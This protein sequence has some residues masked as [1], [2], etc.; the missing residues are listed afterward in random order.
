MGDEFAV[1]AHAFPMQI[2]AVVQF[3]VC[4]QFDQKLREC[5]EAAR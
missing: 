5:A 3:P 2:P 1:I 4:L